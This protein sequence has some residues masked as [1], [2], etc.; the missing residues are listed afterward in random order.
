MLGD[1]TVLGDSTASGGYM[2]LDI[3]AALGGVA[4]LV[5]HMPLRD[6]TILR[7]HD[8]LENYVALGD[9]AEGGGG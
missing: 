6:L 1:S 7:G 5:K 4:A 3:C 8:T 2:I 9:T